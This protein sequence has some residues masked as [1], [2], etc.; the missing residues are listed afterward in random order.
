MHFKPSKLGY[1][2]YELVSAMQKSIRRNDPELAMF[3]FMEITYTGQYYHA[4]KR[5]LVTA[6]EDIGLAAPV[7][8]ERAEHFADRAK[9]WYRAKSDAWVLVISNIILMLSAAPKC[10]EADHFQSVIQ[11]RRLNGW[12]PELPDYTYDK[13][14]RKGK[15]L[16]R[17]IDHFRTEGARLNPEP[18]N[19]KYEKEAY[20]Y[21][22]QFEGKSLLQL[23]TEFGGNRQL[24]TEN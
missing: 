23:N 1:N 19:R 24:S 6:H 15:R 18:K 17:G 4:L 8:V 22:S 12:K 2:Y 16:G 5:L 7:V 14:T 3:C 11:G 21:W 10:R 20:Q 13:H 9:E